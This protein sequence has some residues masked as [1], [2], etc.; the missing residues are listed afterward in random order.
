MTNNINRLETIPNITQ[1]HLDNG[2]TNNINRLET[3]PNITQLHL[4]NG[5]TNNINWDQ[6][7]SVP[8]TSTPS[9]DEMVE[10]SERYRART[11]EERFGDEVFKEL[12]SRFR[13]PS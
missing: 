9:A 13:C 7:L 12:K 8:C 6:Q 1:L 2:M 11:G 4:D 3:I 5:M 10:S